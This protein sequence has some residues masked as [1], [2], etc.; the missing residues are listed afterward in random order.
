M[1]TIAVDAMGARDAP[2][3]VVEAV[4]E[5]SLTREVQCVLVGPQDDLQGILESVSYNGANIDIVGASEAVALDEDA[6][7]ARRKRQSSLAVA[8][9]LVA[10]GT[11]DA[12]VTAGNAAAAL[13]I[14]RQTWL[15]LPGMDQVAVAGV[16]PHVVERGDQSPLALLLDVGATI[17]C[18]AA[19]LASFAL[20]GAAYVRAAVGTNDPRI[21]LLNVG[22]DESAGG[23][24]ARAHAHIRRLPG[25]SFTGNVE[26]HELAT[27]RA[28]VIVCE[29]LV[30]NVVLKILHE[31]AGM[32]VDPT[33][34]GRSRSW[35]R[36][37][38]L[39]VLGGGAERRPLLDYESYAGAPLLGFE[40][41]AVTCHPQA[42]ARA[43]GNAIDAA[44]RT[45]Q[46]GMIDA[47][48]EAVKTAA[49]R[50]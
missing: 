7:T 28:D 40:S 47:V 22:P 15:R 5:V 30:G 17:R 13:E 1:P 50:R 32:S 46:H 18:T 21:G 19:E 6:A 23:E 39:A 38:G 49:G 41:I 35:R 27:G 9:R 10:D 44:A 31:F 48:R 8:A 42:R 2:R 45:V 37:A 3:A 43:V 36:R 25:L 20:L 33:G 14:C 16:Y 4:A 29:G 26:G 12:L 24:L 11:A 34:E